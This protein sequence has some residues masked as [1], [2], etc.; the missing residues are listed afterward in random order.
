MRKVFARF[1]ILILMAAAGRTASADPDASQALATSLA[2][3]KGGDFEASLATLE[4]LRGRWEGDPSHTSDLAR[5][6]A[7]TAIA[8]MGL[9]Q[10]ENARAE[11]LRAWKTDPRLSLDPKEFP[12]GVVELFETVRRDAEQRTSLLKVTA[13]PA[14]TASP[15]A[16]HGPSALVVLGA[17]GAAGLGAAIAPAR[18]AQAAPTS[19][20]TP[21][22]S[23]PDISGKW[24]FGFGGI[25]SAS[26]AYIMTL[27]QDG[28]TL[29]GVETELGAPFANVN[30]T[31]TASGRFSLIEHRLQTSIA[32]DVDGQLHGLRDIVGTAY[33]NCCP[34]FQ[35]YP[36]SLQKLD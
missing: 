19:S 32:C 4:R 12:A 2:A 21:L 11:F 5:A 18:A 9:S 13:S 33:C 20:P 16:K 15:R 22:S 24:G 35:S 36:A 10:Q 25:T 31:I 30:G 28:T 6:Y 14:P 17:V 7:Y 34:T 27:S 1:L 8:Y 3:I 26:G 29:T 23:V